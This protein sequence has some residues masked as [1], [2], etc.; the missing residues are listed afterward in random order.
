MIIV[1]LKIHEVSVILVICGLFLPLRSRVVTGR[2]AALGCVV[3]PR[4]MGS[5]MAN[6][7]GH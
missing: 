3:C 4:H 7:C 2:S 1:L 5:S 6:V